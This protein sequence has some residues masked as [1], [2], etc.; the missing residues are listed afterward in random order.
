MIG[1][2]LLAVGMDMT[3]ESTGPHVVLAS[4]GERLDTV[5]A[6]GIRDDD[7]INAI[8]TT[9]GLHV[10]E[11]TVEPD[12]DMPDHMRLFGA[13]HEASLSDLLRFGMVR[14]GVTRTQPEP[15]PEPEHV[16]LELP[17]HGNPDGRHVGIDLSSGPDQSAVVEMHGDKVVSVT[18]EEA[19][20]AQRPIAVTGRSRSAAAEWARRNGLVESKDWVWMPTV[21]HLVSLSPR[22]LV[23]VAGFPGGDFA[24]QVRRMRRETLH[25]AVHDRV[26][27]PY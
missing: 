12:E 9:P 2:I 20:K 21:R 3:R 17:Q 4:E 19:P 16:H 23:V 26:P 6:A 14:T 18:T 22:P 7:F 15:D 5:L 8:P 1:S 13:W 24:T 10:W 11:G 25:V 27:A